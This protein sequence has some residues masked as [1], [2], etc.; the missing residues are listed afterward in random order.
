MLDGLVAGISNNIGT[1]LIIAAILAASFLLSFFFKRLLGWYLKRFEDSGSARLSLA[2]TSFASK[3]V[4]ILIYSLA[5]MTIL[6]E[7]QIEISPLLAGLGI[8]GITVALAAKETLSNFFSAITVLTDRPYKTGDRIAL[9]S[10]ESGDVIE[11][12]M[13][14]TRI[15]TLDNRVII[16][17]NAR[18]TSS[19]IDNRSMT[20]HSLRYTIPIS[21][22]YDADLEKASAILL[23]IVK[24]MRG[25]R[26]KP[27]PEV[28]VSGLGEYSVDLVLLVWAE[29]FRRDCDIPDRV[30]PQAVKR[31]AAEGIE[32]PYPIRTI[33]YL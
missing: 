14:N 11:I 7:L 13:R 8:V 6:A 32:M 30:Y 18:I 1:L 12:G 26:E 9:P 28:Y 31:F 5:L 22:A 25:V 15:K 20:D 10:G 21:I 2:M 4:S 16:V 24:G 23:D 33:N 17:P 29:N 27:A 3:A 19:W